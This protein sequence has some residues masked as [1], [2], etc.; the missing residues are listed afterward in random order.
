MKNLTQNSKKQSFFCYNFCL[1]TA[2]KHA[3]FLLRI[4]W[5]FFHSS[6]IYSI[7]QLQGLR[8]LP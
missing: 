6:P 7:N 2:T 4:C 8:F 1:A 5:Y 3:K